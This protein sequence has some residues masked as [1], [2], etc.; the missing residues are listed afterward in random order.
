MLHPRK[1]KTDRL[2]GCPDVRLILVLVLGRQTVH[3]QNTV[4]LCLSKY[5]VFETTHTHIDTVAS[6]TEGVPAVSCMESHMNR[7]PLG[8]IDPNSIR[9]TELHSECRRRRERESLYSPQHDRDAAP[10][11]AA[12]TRLRET[13][14]AR[15]ERLRAD[16]QRNEAPA[17]DNTSK[18]GEVCVSI[19]PGLC[20][21]LCVSVLLALVACK[22]VWLQ[23]STSC[24]SRH[25]VSY[26]V[27]AYLVSYCLLERV[28]RVTGAQHRSSR[29]SLWSTSYHTAVACDTSSL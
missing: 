3:G 28:S 29:L 8:S 26:I 24:V 25:P 20:L 19:R 22:K 23:K 27:S 5:I 21:C 1:K 9:E 15:A 10:Q 4:Y 7:R 14:E 12:A 2:C 13:N 6:E 11:R 18:R 17:G 16:R